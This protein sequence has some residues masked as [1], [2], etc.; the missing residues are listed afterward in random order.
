VA[1]ACRLRYGGVAAAVL[2]KWVRPSGEE[3]LHDRRVTALG[4]PHQGGCILVIAS[5]YVRP[6]LQQPLH[7]REVVGGCRMEE[8]SIQ[9]KT[10]HAP[11]YSTAASTPRMTSKRLSGVIR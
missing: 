4:G 11:V 5:V 1:F 10:T 6:F 8:R 3:K 9:E 7:G 2:G